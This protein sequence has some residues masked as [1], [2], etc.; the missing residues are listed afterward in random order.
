MAGRGVGGA[1]GAFAP[2]LQGG[3]V[4]LLVEALA[5]CGFS[6]N[7][8]YGIAP[9]SL[10][11]WPAASSSRLRPALAC[12]PPGSVG[13]PG[14]GGRVDQLRTLQAEYETW[15]DGLRGAA[16]G[17]LRDR[18]RRPRRRTAAGVRTRLN[19]TARRA[20]VIARGRV[21]KSPRPVVQGAAPRRAGGS[22]RLQEDGRA[23]RGASATST[24]TPSTSRCHGASAATEAHGGREAPSD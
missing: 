13:S 8:L 9:T 19:A 2:G 11:H 3:A 17:C 23:A 12:G 5:D 22:V 16:R 15:R 18:P 6:A 1:S 20:T 4:E 14:A 7:R 24:S 10:R 21:G